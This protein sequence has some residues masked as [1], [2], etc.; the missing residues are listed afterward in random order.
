MGWRG[1]KWSLFF[2]IGRVEI[3]IGKDKYFWLDKQYLERQRGR[4]KYYVFK[5]LVV[6]IL[7]VS[8]GREDWEEAFRLSYKQF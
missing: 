8:R 7:L 1:W 5:D 4:Y 3:I 2:I 6:E